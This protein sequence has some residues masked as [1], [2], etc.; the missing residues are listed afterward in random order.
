MEL[1]EIENTCGKNIWFTFRICPFIMLLYVTIFMIFFNNICLISFVYI[2]INPLVDLLKI[3]NSSSSFTWFS[4]L[5]E[6]S[7]RSYQGLAQWGGKLAES[8]NPVNLKASTLL[9][10][11]E[12]PYF[13]GTLFWNS[14]LKKIEQ[15]KFLLPTDKKKGTWGDSGRLSDTCMACS[16]RPTPAKLF[17]ILRSR[18]AYTVFYHFSWETNIFHKKMKNLYPEL[19]VPSLFSSSSEQVKNQV[20]RLVLLLVIHILVFLHALDR[21]YKLIYS[22]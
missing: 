5:Y 17:F 2:S 21:C 9:L 16:T 20:Q 11:R 8:I 14:A 4:A 7:I 13:V 3:L 10:L 18:K 19:V 15:K 1:K 22:F 12:I 6:V